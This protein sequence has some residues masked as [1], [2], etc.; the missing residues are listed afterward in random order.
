MSY[1]ELS[2]ASSF[3]FLLCETL[4]NSLSHSFYIYCSFKDGNR[5]KVSENMGGDR[6]LH[7]LA[8]LQ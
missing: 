6:I 8:Y 7:T 5:I 4:M 3:Q 2:K 1:T